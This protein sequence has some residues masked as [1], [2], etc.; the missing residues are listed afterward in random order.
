V[1]KPAQSGAKMRAA[2]QGGIEAPTQ[3]FSILCFKILEAQ[4]F[5]YP[6][7]ENKKAA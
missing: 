3:E 4:F 5:S 2:L 1:P 7:P 6:I